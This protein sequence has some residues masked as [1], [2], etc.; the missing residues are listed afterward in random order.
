[1]SERG[2]WDTHDCYVV[3]GVN[4]LINTVEEVPADKGEYNM[5]KL[6]MLCYGETHSPYRLRNFKPCMGC[7]THYKQGICVLKRNSAIMLCIKCSDCI[8]AKNLKYE[9]SLYYFEGFYPRLEGGASIYSVV[10]TLY[11]ISP[12]KSPF[13][14]N[15][16]KK[17]YI[18]ISDFLRDP[19]TSTSNRTFFDTLRD[20]NCYF[21]SRLTKEEIC[22]G[23]N[24]KRFELTI[25]RVWIFIYNE[26]GFPKEI[27]NLIVTMV[28]L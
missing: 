5:Y 20:N 23:C 13:G 1:M 17:R 8:K 12:A 6:A 26:C 3:N 10:S 9:G 19:H 22:D 21:C 16:H 14:I 4:L 18:P 11:A 25:S 24:S 27:T 7:P 28:F 15:L 2:S